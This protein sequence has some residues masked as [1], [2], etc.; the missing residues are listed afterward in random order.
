MARLGLAAGEGLNKTKDPNMLFIPE[1][2]LEK[3]LV[4]AVTEPATAPDF[5]RLLL[6]S[7]LLVLGSVEG[8]E[9]A[10]DAFSVAPG[11]NVRL[12][13]GMKDGSQY[14][15]VFSSPA[16]LQDYVKQES[17]FLRVNGRA[18]LD[19]TRGAPL[20]LNPA[21]LYGKELTADMIGQLLDGPRS[22]RAVAGEAVG[23]PTALLEMLARLFATRPEIEAAWMIQVT[24]AERPQDAHPLIGIET[25]SPA[26]G[27]WP[28][29]IQAIEAAARTTVPGMV[30]DVQRVDRYSPAGMAGALLQTEPF[31]RRHNAEPIFN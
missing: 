6:A 4:R 17:K 14:L 25:V 21:S 16:R 20:I 8:H 12:V 28:S 2:E 29:L 5:Y 22:I 10:T 15:P 13:T 30:F 19:L 26:P 23:Y 18:L 27:D 24:Q 11:S 7:D 31:Y 9:N 3:A 1:N